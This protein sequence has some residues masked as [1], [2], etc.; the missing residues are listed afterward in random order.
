MSAM[1]QADNNP[2]QA[3]QDIDEMEKLLQEY[4]GKKNTKKD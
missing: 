3:M 4:K 1:V 2:D